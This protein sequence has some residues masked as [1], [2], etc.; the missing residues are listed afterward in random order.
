[1]DDH[2]QGLSK[3]PVSEQ[4]DET[5]KGSVAATIK[6]IIAGAGIGGGYAVA[7]ALKSA[8]R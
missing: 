4:R 3:P 5:G 8:G 2:Y 6:A 1:M 7:R